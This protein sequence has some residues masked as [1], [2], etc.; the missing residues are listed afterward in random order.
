VL[1]VKEDYDGAEPSGN[2]VAA[3]N[4]LRLA[5]MT[6]R[7][8]FREAGERTLAGF[9]AKLDAAPSAVPQMLAACEFLLGDPREVVLVGDRGGEDTAALIVELHSRFSRPTRWRCWWIRPRRGG[10]W[11][12][13]FRPSNPCACFKAALRLTFAATM[14]ARRRYP[15]LRSSAS[16]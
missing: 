11:R 4:L 13:A 3:M 8:E 10:S 7:G 6:G 16:C 14:P 5:R 1:Q 2:S 12:R 9:S 15:R